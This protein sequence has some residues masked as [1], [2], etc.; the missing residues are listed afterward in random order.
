MQNLFLDLYDLI[1]KKLSQKDILHL[2]LTCKNMYFKTKRYLYWNI[3]WDDPECVSNIVSKLYFNDLENYFNF[4]K[5][6]SCVLHDWFSHIPLNNYIKQS[7]SNGNLSNAFYCNKESGS[8]SESCNKCEY[9][10]NFVK[11]IE[12]LKNITINL[13]S[14]E[15]Y[16]KVKKKSEG[17]EN[18]YKKRKVNSYYLCNDSYNGI[19][20][21]NLYRRIFK[22]QN[23]NCYNFLPN[24]LSLNCVNLRISD[25]YVRLKDVNVENLEI[26]NCEDFWVSVDNLKMLVFNNCF[27]KTMVLPHVDELT[28]I[29]SRIKHNDNVIGYM[30]CFQHVKKL[31]LINCTLESSFVYYF[32]KLVEFSEVNTTGDYAFNI[33]HPIN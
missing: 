11:I 25:T 24:P 21:T 30:H 9:Y 14:E 33:T 10:K 17:L 12:N 20:M 26:I 15:E 23:V 1:V 27:V 29:N 2:A 19:N 7:S 32:P 5:I 4:I 28:I 8:E 22:L 18:I 6:V 13:K 31:K 3:T 16:E